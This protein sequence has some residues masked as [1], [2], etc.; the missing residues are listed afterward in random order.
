MKMAL[1]WAMIE[2]TESGG[3]RGFKFHKS[4]LSEEGFGLMMALAYVFA[5]NIPIM[6][7]HMILWP[8]GREMAARSEF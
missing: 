4:N 5:L 8:I 7:G 2:F 3:Q 6:S 1:M